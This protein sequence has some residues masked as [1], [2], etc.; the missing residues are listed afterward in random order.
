[1]PTPTETPITAAAGAQFTI[2]VEANPT[3]GYEWSPDFGRDRI[4]LVRREFAT[5]HERAGATGP[6]I[7]SGRVERFVFEALAEGAT[8]VQLRLKRA[9]ETAPVDER[10]YRVVVRR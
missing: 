3:T 2:E 7:G 8:S 4:R 1:V 9:W 10:T 5:V 6:A